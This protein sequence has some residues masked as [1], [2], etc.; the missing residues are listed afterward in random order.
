MIKVKVT[1]DR[2]SGSETR[3]QDAQIAAVLDQA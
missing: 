2:P 3:A 1:D